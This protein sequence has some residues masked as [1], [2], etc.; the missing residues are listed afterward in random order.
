MI[1][2]WILYNASDFLGE[3]LSSFKMGSTAVVFAGLFI[4]TVV[5]TMFMNAGGGVTIAA[6]KLD[7]TNDKSICLFMVQAAWNLQSMY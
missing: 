3:G 5:G 2:G 4:T 1:F 7:G 6:A